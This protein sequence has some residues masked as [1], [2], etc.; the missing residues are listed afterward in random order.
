MRIIRIGDPATAGSPCQEKFSISPKKLWQASCHNCADR[1]S[2]PL[3]G[4][5][6][7]NFPPC[8]ELFFVRRYVIT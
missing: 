3:L 5:F 6:T 2:T 4:E 1:Q 7:R 8:Q